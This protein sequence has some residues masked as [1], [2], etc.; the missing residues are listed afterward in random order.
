MVFM[1]LREDIP[2]P[3]KSRMKLGPTTLETFCCQER[4]AKETLASAGA[5]PSQ[6]LRSHHVDGPVDVNDVQEVQN[7]VK[8]IPVHFWEAVDQL[9][10]VL[11]LILFG[12]IL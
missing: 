10:S 8:C 4:I 5:L 9:A 11:E 7:G 1:K 3:A 12:F 6:V 2:S